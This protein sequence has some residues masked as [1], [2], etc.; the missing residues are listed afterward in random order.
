MQMCSSVGYIETSTSALA[1]ASSPALLPPAQFA[2]PN[3]LLKLP[4]HDDVECR[5]HLLVENAA[6]PVGVAVPK[7]TVVA[8]VVEQ[9]RTS[10]NPGQ[11]R[12]PLVDYGICVVLGTS[13]HATVKT[14]HETEGHGGH[15]GR[16]D[17]WRRLRGS[18][19]CGKCGAAG[20]I[21]G[22]R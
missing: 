4:S 18:V 5:G 12:S 3:R 10:P 11:P 20:P 1:A 17:T 15:E 21:S 2:L 16:S 13:L 22:Q 9:A 6:V 19:E 8:A 7:N 14:S